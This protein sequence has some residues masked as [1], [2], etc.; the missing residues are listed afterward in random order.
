MVSSTSLRLSTVVPATR[1]GDENRVHEVTNIDLAMKLHYIKGVYFFKNEAVEGLTIYDLKKPM[2]QLLQLYFTASGRIRRSETGMPFIKC[3]D[4]GVRIVEAHYEETVDEWSARAM[5]DSSLFD[6]LAYNQA[7]GPD[8]GYSPLVFLHSLGLKCGG[9]AVGLSWANVLR[10]AFS[11]SAFMNMW[12][13]IIA[14]QVPWKLLH[15]P[16]PGKPESPSLSSVPETPFSVK[17][18]DPVG[19]FWVTQGWATFMAGGEFGT[20]NVHKGEFGV[21]SN[22]IVWS[23]VAADFL[24][25]EAEVSDLVELIVKKRAEENGAIEETARREE[26]G[27]NSDFIA[28]GAKLTFVNLEEA[29][30]YGLELKGQKPVY[31][32]YG[33]S[34]VGDEGLVLVLPASTNNVGR[35]LS[36]V[37]PEN[38][39][40]Q[41]KSELQRNWSIA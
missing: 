26:G 13:K 39:L 36:V 18:V 9:M 5:D 32:S 30:I 19:D 38:Q 23:T 35:L 8:L 15:V 27:S 12:G 14:G 21:L 3:N 10:D 40:T 34:G 31:A 25:A 11:A 37:R 16:L 29:E 20:K 41:L 17:R 7:L 6:G 28:Y 1:I 2:F 33:I 4:S 22:D 24:V